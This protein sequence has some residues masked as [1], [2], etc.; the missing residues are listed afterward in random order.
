MLPRRAGRHKDAAASYAQA[1]A[2]RG[3][4]AERRYLERRLREVR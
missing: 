4:A 1:I 3:N 2:L